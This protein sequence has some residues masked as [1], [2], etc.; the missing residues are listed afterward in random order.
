MD[1]NLTFRMASVNDFDALYQLDKNSDKIHHWKPGFFSI[2]DFIKIAI[3]ANKIAGFVVYKITDVVEILRLSTHID[4]K[5]KTVATA[6]IQQLK[7][8]QK[9]IILELRASNIAAYNLYKKLGFKVIA[10]R[11][12]YYSNAEN[13]KIMR[14]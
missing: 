3:I 2:K 13:A 5:N 1:C 8:Q 12:K 6:L 14:F 11:E 10:Q 4:F 9:P 7:Q